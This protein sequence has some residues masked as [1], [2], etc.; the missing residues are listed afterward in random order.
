MGER[1][2]RTPN[3][4]CS[5]CGTQIYRRPSE[6]NANDGRAYC[7]QV[8]YGVSCRREK[9]C[10]M[11]GKLILSG[12]RKKTCSRSCAN[13]YREGI[14]YKIN[15]PRDIVHSQHALKLRLIR[16]RG[17]KCERCGYERFEILQVHHKN[18]ERADNRILNLELI[19]PNCHCEEHYIEKSGWMKNGGVG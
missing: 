15:R 2:V 6:L 13:K 9:P 1:Y 4:K 14:Q 10:A 11:C 12:L 19:C 5:I 7:S 17:K 3:T 8:C 18:R 16:E